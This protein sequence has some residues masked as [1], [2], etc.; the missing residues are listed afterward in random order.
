MNENFKSIVTSKVDIEKY[1]F[2]WLSEPRSNF[3]NFLDLAELRLSHKLNIVL[4]YQIEEQKYRI[5][6]DH[7]RLNF[8]SPLSDDFFSYFFA[9]YVEPARKVGIHLSEEEF[10]K[11]R[12][13]F[14]SDLDALLKS[15]REQKSKKDFTLNLGKEDWNDFM[16]VLEN[17]MLMNPMLTPHVSLM[18]MATVR[19]ADFTTTFTQCSASEFY[20]D[21]PLSQGKSNFNLIF[22]YLPDKSPYNPVAD[23]ILQHKELAAIPFPMPKGLPKDM[24]LDV[25]AA[26]FYLFGTP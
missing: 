18:Y 15:F 6:F 20:I 3:E 11:R 17:N 8:E 19:S 21:A 25:F 24:P 23:W 1:G 12:A 14:K 7:I 4:A 9:T 5:Y 16:T 10:G 13:E 2:V 26:L 22:T